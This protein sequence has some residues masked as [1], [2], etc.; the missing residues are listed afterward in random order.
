MRKKL[1][2]I[3]ILAVFGILLLLAVG[4]FMKN[5]TLENE[6]TVKRPEMVE[7][8]SVNVEFLND[9]E[10]YVVANFGF[11]TA[12][13]NM[14]SQISRDIFHTSGVD[15]VVLGNQGYLYYAD[16]VNDYLGIVSLNEREQ[17]NIVHSLE[18]IQDYVQ[19][20]GAK[21]LFLIAPNKNSL[22]D[23]MPYNYVKASEE[24]NADKILERLTNVNTIDL[25]ELFRNQS[26][27][28]YH[29]LDSHWNNQGAYL[30]FQEMLKNFFKETDLYK[31]VSVEQKKDFSG[32]LYKM[33]NPSGT[34]KDWNYYYS[35]ENQYRYVTRTRSV[36]Q[37]YIETENTEEEGSLLMFRDSFGNA[38]LPFLANV[39]KNAVFD[40]NIPYD[41]RK[42]DVYQADTVVIEIAERNL[43]LIQEN[44][45]FF[46]A[47]LRQDIEEN[48]DSLRTSSDILSI[49][50]KGDDLVEQILIEQ[51]EDYTC[52]KGSL[53]SEQCKQ[54]DK[55]Y[56][57]TEDGIYELTPQKI[58]DNEYGFCGYFAQEID[59]SKAYIEVFR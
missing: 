51:N 20:K 53:V 17:F 24:G 12:F 3:Y 7:N 28:L 52:I 15:S 45:P 43:S 36:E 2:L 44:M 34:E 19:G 33:L 57:K 49:Q 4:T 48:A 22:Y 21:F 10:T 5:E 41:M 56:L 47:P 8:H 6:Q 50:E 29:K 39:Y 14:N 23:Y 27:E 58:D 35:V 11:R 18:L 1:E 55:I 31:D 30:V 32:D 42:M 25:F 46:F 16:T 38:L 37:S 13:I 26:E 9:F 40:K 59:W 54:E